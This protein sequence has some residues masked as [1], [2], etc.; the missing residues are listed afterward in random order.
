ML[1]LREPSR[2]DVPLCDFA[3]TAAVAKEHTS[4]A[5]TLCLVHGVV[6][7][8]QDVGG[9]QSHGR[10][11]GYADTCRGCQRLAAHFDRLAERRQEFASEDLSALWFCD[12]GEEN[13]EFIATEAGGRIHI[14]GD[15]SNPYCRDSNQFVANRVSERVVHSLHPV[16]VHENQRTL[17]VESSGSKQGVAE[18]AFEFAPIGETGEWIGGR[19][20][21]ELRR[22]SI[23]SSAKTKSRRP[24]RSSA[25]LCELRT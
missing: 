11:H 23:L 18:F 8:L 25:L 21:L 5:C 9:I 19:F 16:E 1:P 15:S 22:L 20:N 4:T 3:K 2:G 17:S 13:D 12:L 14:S 6:R 7:C 10:E 24:G